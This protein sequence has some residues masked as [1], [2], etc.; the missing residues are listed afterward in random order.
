MGVVGGDVFFLL[1]G[2]CEFECCPIWYVLDGCGG[3]FF[4]L[5]EEP[6]FF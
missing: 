5:I 1:C 2:V 4:D 3:G 6:F